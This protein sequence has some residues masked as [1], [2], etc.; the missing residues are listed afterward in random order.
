MRLPRL[1][2]SLVL[3]AAHC[4]AIVA[5]GEEISY[6]R[7][8]GGVT[9][10]DQQP[11]PD[12]L[13]DHS[14]A[15]R[16][17]LASGHSTPC[18]SGD[19]MYLTAFENDELATVAI[20]R[21][22]GKLL[23]RKVAPAT[24]LE[25]YHS[26]SSPAAAT[27]ACDGQRVYVFF[28]S[29]G[30]LCYDLQGKLVWSK[31]MGPFQDEFGSAS[32]PIIVDGKL[33]VSA[34]HDVH[35]FLLAVD[36]QTG[37]EIWR[38]ARDGFTRSYATPLVW[39]ADGRKQLVVAGA[40]Q[41]VAYDLDNGEKLWWVNGLARIVNTTPAQGLGLLFVATWSPGGDTDA[42]IAMPP[43]QTALESWDDNGDG[44]L[45][46]D[47][48]KDPDVLDRFY[49]IDL[50]QDGGLDEAEWNK[51]AR[52]F[53]LAENSLLA[54]R[55]SGSGDITGQAVVWQYRKGL[56]YVPSPLLY[57]ERLY[58]VKNGGILTCLDAKTG[59][60]QKQLRLSSSE[61]YYA[62][63][64][65]G[66]GKVYVVSE[67]GVVNVLDAAACRVVFKRDFAE[68]TMATPVLAE[69]R[70]YLRTEQALYCFERPR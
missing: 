49:R 41:L 51:Y 68:R 55:P 1:I 57:H 26:T 50:N 31:E 69:G 42:R 66:D 27:P 30:L 65:A 22:T 54:I 53:E 14:L 35:S 13:D 45:S 5:F 20:D 46:H 16:V 38:A 11:L 17:P 23:W 59:R 7:Y 58:L 48:A 37:D 10:H 34:D 64:V 40:L 56:P 29:Y 67:P 15:W 24:R 61:N 60:M 44:L 39:E 21:R 36:C 6:F 47:E 43:W 12:R 2:V 62:S 9:D 4:T 32:S 19:A 18:V 52:V 70:V 8:D 33:I 25:Q 28:G 63:P 3:A